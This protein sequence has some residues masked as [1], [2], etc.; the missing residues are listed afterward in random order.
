MG[1]VVPWVVRCGRRMILA[2]DVCAAWW[3]W[4]SGARGYKR[5]DHAAGDG[6]GRRRA[7]AGE[8]TPPLLQHC[9]SLTHCVVETLALRAMALLGPTAK[10]AQQGNRGSSPD[11]LDVPR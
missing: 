4:Y 7:A 2:F 6:D 10:S 8:P 3:Q 9:R 11:A 1:W 5:A